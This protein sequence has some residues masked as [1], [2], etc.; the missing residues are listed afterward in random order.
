MQRIVDRLSALSRADGPREAIDL[1]G[2]LGDALEFVQPTLE[3]KSITVL[4]SLSTDPCMVIGNPAE[5]EQLFLNLLLNAYDATS[6][7]GTVIVEA[8]R[9]ETEVVVTVSDSGP[10]IAPE[11][12][13]KV[14]EPFITTKARGSGL[15]LAISAGIVRTHG[16]RLRAANRPDGGAM[17]TA[18]FPVAASA[19][20]TIA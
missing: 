5:L 10:G 14:F 2:P 6:S 19:S 1:R 8:T 9:L 15:G 7:G 20:A 3:E 17:F 12:L 4:A 18:E 11:L 13:H 16:G